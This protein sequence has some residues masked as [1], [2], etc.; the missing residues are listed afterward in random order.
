MDELDPPFPQ[1][2]SSAPPPTIPLPPQGPVHREPLP[3][4]EQQRAYERENQQASRLSVLGGIQLIMIGVFP[5]V[6]FGLAMSTRTND[7][8]GQTMTL[9]PEAF[10]LLLGLIAILG[11][12]YRIARR[13]KI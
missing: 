3:S 5:W 10:L 7:I 4:P 2:T 12:L 6:L 13:N 9:G 8:T 1:A 11:G